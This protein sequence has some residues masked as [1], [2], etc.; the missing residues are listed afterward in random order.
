MPFSRHSLSNPAFTSILVIGSGFLAGC[1][2]DSGAAGTFAVRDSAGIRIAESSA[3]LWGEGESWR[4]SDEPAVEIG[5]LDGEPEYQLYQADDGARLR[6]GR[7]VVGNA[8]T[9][10]LRIY[11]SDGAYLGSSGREGEGPGEFGSMGL[12]EVL[13]GDSVLTWDWQNNRAQVFDPQIEFVR[14]FRLGSGD[15]ESGLPPAPVAALP[16]G[17]L[18]TR[19]RR[20][21]MPGDDMGVSRD[22]ILY[23][24]HDA[25]G[26]LIDTIA[27]FP[28]AEY[29]AS[30]PAE[31]AM[32]VTPLPFGLSPRFAASGD[33]FYFGASDA[34]EIGYY[35]MDGALTRLIRLPRPTLQVTANDRERY[36][37]ERLEAASENWRPTLQ[38]MLDE[39]P[40]PEAMPAYSDIRADA[41]GN[42]W[43]G[44]YRRPGDE[45]PRWNVFDPDGRWL[46]SLETPP[47]FEIYEIGADYVLG[48]HSDELD[49][50]SVR[51]YDLEKPD[52]VTRR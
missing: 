21:F 3:P 7:I 14:S 44:E 15:S 43:V 37:E 1:G 19:E 30:S 16:D 6:D 51:L 18:L 39:M 8:G 45:Q 11:D 52:Q 17:T 26:A 5:V 13:A 47:R 40:F 4:L 20:V 27:R 33:G 10:E 24:H 48:R 2:S 50:E 9:H 32:S 12:L 35:R 38:R 49:V 42:L 46:G 34:Y 41:E 25:T 28:S 23:F 31:G 29:Y 36:A 22:S